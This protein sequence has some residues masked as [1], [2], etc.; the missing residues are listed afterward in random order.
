MA[1]SEQERAAFLEAAAE[2][3]DAEEMLVRFVDETA[4][5]R[6]VSISVRE[7]SLLEKVICQIQLAQTECGRAA[8]GE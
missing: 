4:A 6:R 8:K 3:A 2:W 7:S 1:I 5:G